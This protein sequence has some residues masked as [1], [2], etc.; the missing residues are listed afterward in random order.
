MNL[1]DPSLPKASR[2]PQ[3]GLDLF[4]DDEPTT[5]WIAP[6]LAECVLGIDPS[7]TGLAICYSVPG[8]PL[9]E[10]RWSSKPAVGVRERLERYET[11]IRG[12]LD[13]VRAIKPGLIV[14]EAPSF[15]SAHR[16]E[17]GHHDRAELRGIL[18]LKLSQLTTCPI[19][20]PAP[21]TLKKYGA[22]DGAIRKGAMMSV[23]TLKY[24]RK[25][26]TDDEMDAFICCQ[27]GLAL[28]GQ[29]PPSR[30]K[31]ERAYLAKLA[32]SYGLQVPA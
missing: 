27:L 28:T 23:V 13:I 26:R 15:G 8:K 21:G 14:I 3:P 30:N 29:L 22:D 25:F 12:T 31:A 20:E 5:K 9:V 16:G 10:G 18:L 32:A 6:L 1:L 19:I 2:Q 24:G 17:R 11:L 7:L 4:G